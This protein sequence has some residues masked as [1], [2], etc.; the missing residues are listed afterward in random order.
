MACGT[1]GGGG[2]NYRPT[3]TI[4]ISNLTKADIDFQPK[5]NAVLKQILT[6]RAKQV[7][8]DAELI[9]SAKLTTK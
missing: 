7:E 1:C 5:T 8:Q 9:R 3:A 4:N 6:D 2:G